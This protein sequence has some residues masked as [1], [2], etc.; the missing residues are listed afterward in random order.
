MCFNTAAPRKPKND[1]AFNATTLRGVFPLA[2][3]ADNQRTTAGNLGGFAY[4][5]NGNPTTYNSSTSGNFAFDPEDRLTSVS[6]FNASTRNLNASYGADGLRAKKTAG[7]V[8]R[9]F[10][11][12]LPL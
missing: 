3:N 2:H 5:G 11:H 6:V 10:L 4:D 7:G 9:W 12:E 1:A 8:T